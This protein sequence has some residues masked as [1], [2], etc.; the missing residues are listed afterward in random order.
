MINPIMRL[1]RLGLICTWCLLAGCGGLG[2]V[3][4]LVSGPQKVPAMHHLAPDRTLVLVDDPENKLGNPA[5][6]MSI[7]DMIGRFL[8]ENQSETL[9]FVDTT[10]LARLAAEMG[11]DYHAT[12]VDAIAA[13]L[14]AQQVI[15]VYIEDTAMQYGGN[16]YRPTAAVQVKVIDVD[17]GVR[18]FPNP[19]PLKESSTLP[20]HKLIVQMKYQHVDDQS[21]ANRNIIT[22]KLA[23]TIAR[24][25]SRLFYQW[26]MPEPGEALREKTG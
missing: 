16:M 21:R 20:G 26:E 2:Y 5:L 19:G 11:N 13:E 23:E 15:H 3:A 1:G 22:G 18:T 25:V 8:I 17:D 7:A 14:N 10:E 9:E 4:A 12:P 6:C 24:D